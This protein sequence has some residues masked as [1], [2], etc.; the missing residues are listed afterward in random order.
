MRGSN[1]QGEILFYF[2]IRQREFPMVHSPPEKKE[3]L[4]STLHRAYTSHSLLFSF[5]GYT[6]KAV[7]P[8][9]STGLPSSTSNAPPPPDPREMLTCSSSL[10]LVDRQMLGAGDSVFW[11]PLL[12]QSQAATCLSLDPL[13]PRFWPR[14]PNLS[15]WFRVSP[16]I[17]VS[18]RC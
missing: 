4:L 10:T 14:P 6:Y 13:N 17:Q 5:G 2:F 15:S 12:L 1:T 11:G 18:H 9:H 3:N 8:P 16:L 7:S